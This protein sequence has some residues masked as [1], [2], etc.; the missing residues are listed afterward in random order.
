MDAVLFCEGVLHRLQ[1]VAA[2]AARKGRSARLSC[3]VRCI[4]GLEGACNE[5]MEYA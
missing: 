3:D 5:S 1:L 2:H 4:Q